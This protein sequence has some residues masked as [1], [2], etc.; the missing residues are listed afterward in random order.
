MEYR[1]ANRQDIDMFVKNRVEFATSIRDID[2]VPAFEKKTKAYVEA[3]I[4]SDLV[5]FLAVDNGAIIASCM[6]CIYHTAPLPGCLSGN[7][8]EIF[9][10][11]T[12]KEHR[13]K[14]HAKMLLN[15]T[16]DEVRKRGVEV[17]RLDYT[18]DGL[19]L[20]EQLGFTLAEHQMQLIL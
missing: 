7:I 6:A 14:G 9:N 3:H 4:D 16:I 17:V 11:Y 20:Y 1:K 18:D 5:V 2:D 13:R 12:K 15:K 19:R 10:V 8:A